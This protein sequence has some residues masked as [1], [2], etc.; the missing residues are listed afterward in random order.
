M[1]ENHQLKMLHCYHNSIYKTYNIN[2]EDNIHVFIY[3]YILIF[4]KIK[5]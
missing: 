1:I 3:I 2:S 4:D 5:G